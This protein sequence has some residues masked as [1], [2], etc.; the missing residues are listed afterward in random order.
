MDSIKVIGKIVLP[1]APQ[2]HK[3]VCHDC[4]DVLDDSCGDP[5]SR[6]TTEWKDG[7]KEERWI[8]DYCADEQF[9]DHSPYSIFG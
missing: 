5:R 4:G 8:C 2:K 6:V 1:D 3:C 9:G 7:R